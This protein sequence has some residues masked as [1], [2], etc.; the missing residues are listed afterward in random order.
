[1][2]FFILRF[3]L[4]ERI[5]NE[6]SIMKIIFSRTRD[7]RI[8]YNVYNIGSILVGIVVYYNSAQLKYKRT[9]VI[10]TGHRIL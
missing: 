3:C 1:M 4:Q 9:Y 5:E 7:F 2:F 10:C 8:P 6:K